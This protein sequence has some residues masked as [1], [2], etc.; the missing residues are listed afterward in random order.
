MDKKIWEAFIN[1]KN[2]G[3]KILSWF[4]LAMIIV[5]YGS[6]Y[7]YIQ[8][9]D[10]V[11]NASVQSLIILIVTAI[12]GNYSKQYYFNLVSVIIYYNEELET[13]VM[14]KWKEIVDTIVNYVTLLLLQV[15]LMH[16]VENVYFTVVGTIIIS[17]LTIS[18]VIA[19]FFKISSYDEY[20]SK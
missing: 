4:Y 17:F 5:M 16:G 14:K 1:E 12:G 6:V 7:F 18:L 20:F 19:Q 2:L 10:N 9:S 8:F 15:Y 11:K 3:V 13:V